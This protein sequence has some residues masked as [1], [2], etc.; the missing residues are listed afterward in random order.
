MTGRE[1]LIMIDDSA[2]AANQNLVSALK[3]VRSHDPEA[4]AGTLLAI[5][6]Q[7]AYANTIA[8]ALFY[9]DHVEGTDA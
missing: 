6:S 4:V 2:E 1:F 7:L 9:L 3:R 5:A 8:A